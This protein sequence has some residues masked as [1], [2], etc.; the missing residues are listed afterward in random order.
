MWLA[1]GGSGHGFK[2]G[3]AVGAYVAKRLAGGAPEPLVA[4]TA[5]RA[6]RERAVL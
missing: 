2:L 3:P 1:G 6:G 5:H 4:L